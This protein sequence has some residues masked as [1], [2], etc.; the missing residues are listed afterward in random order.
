MFVAK[1]ILSHYVTK[2]G[3]KVKSSALIG[4]G[5]DA[6]FDAILSEELQKVYPSYKIQITP[7][8]DISD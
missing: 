8:I 2:Q 6:F 7:D 4:S 1:I 5:K 3:E